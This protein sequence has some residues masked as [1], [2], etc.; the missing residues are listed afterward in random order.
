MRR[1]PG[2][3]CFCSV[4]LP[5]P[6][7]T[8]VCCAHTHTHTQSITNCQSSL[9]YCRICFRL[10]HSDGPLAC[11][12]SVLDYSVFNPIFYLIQLHI[13]QRTFLPV[14]SSRSFYSL[15]FRQS[16]LLAHVHLTLFVSV[17]LS[18]LVIC[19]FSKIF[20]FTS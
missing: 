20:A 2:S 3:E 5:F 17:L 12:Q 7:H 18:Q 10:T 19:C 11:Y 15:S 16:W 9:V 8:S 4:L 1:T 13:S 14:S 6:H